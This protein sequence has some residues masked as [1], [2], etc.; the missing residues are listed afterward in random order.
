[1]LL[2]GGWCRA[3]APSGAPKA[4]GAGFRIVFMRFVIAAAVLFS[5]PA[6]VAQQSEAQR[7]QDCIEKIDRDAEAAY[8][9]G[10]SWIATGNRPAARHCTAL[11]LIALGQE[12]EGATRLEQL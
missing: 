3:Y 10:L 5:A 1:M 8:Q 4:S 12:A 7:L 6:A 2:T 11:A 9:D